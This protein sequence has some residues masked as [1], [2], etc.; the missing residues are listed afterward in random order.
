[1]RKQA[2]LRLISVT[3]YHWFCKINYMKS[4]FSGNKAFR[5]IGQLE[6]L[7]L[8][9]I[10]ITLAYG[11]FGPAV[12]KWKDIDGIAEWFSSLGIPA[13]HLNAYLAAGTEALGVVLL[14]LGLGVRFISIPL[15]ITMIVAITT[16]HWSNGFEAGDNGFE[17]PL[18]YIIMLIT[19]LV[20][21][22]GKAGLDYWISRERREK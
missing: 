19:L 14:V 7:P 9:L 6:F 2:D 12:M 5:A 16:V 17:I 10:R 1:M 8:L 13:A 11:F 20:F 18:Y 21:G 22:S 3:T 15:I 4:L